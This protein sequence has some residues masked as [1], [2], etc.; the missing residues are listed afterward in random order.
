MDES[1]FQDEDEPVSDDNWHEGPL[2]LG[3]AWDFPHHLIRTAADLADV[4]QVHL[5]CAFVD[6]ASYLTEWEPGWSTALS[7]EP[8]HNAEAQYPSKQVLRRL[9]NI[10]GEPG[11]QWS[12]RVLNGDVPQALGRLATSTG[13]SLMILGGPRPGSIARM[14]RLVEGSVSASLIRTQRW[15]VLVVPQ[16]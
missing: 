15:P 14:E 3:V 11:Q 4:L 7:L 13:T 16:I 6:P 1:E 8:A 10:L 2:I 9:A 5:I 12:F